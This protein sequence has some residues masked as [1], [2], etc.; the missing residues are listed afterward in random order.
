MFSCKKAFVP[1]S[2][3][4]KYLEE[5]T[6]DLCTDL[7]GW[8]WFLFPWEF[9]NLFHSGELVYSCKRLAEYRASIYTFLIEQMRVF[10]LCF[11]SYFYVESRAA[12]GY[13]TY[14][15]KMFLSCCSLF[16]ISSRSCFIYNIVKPQKKNPIW[17]EERNFAIAVLFFFNRI[18]VKLGIVQICFLFSRSV[19]LPCDMMA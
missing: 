1:S 10:L 2:L 8:N 19:S 18:Y 3:M 6:I 9:R 4:R 11:P 7:Y 14:F 5:S 15:F 13:N 16:G 12:L 17:W